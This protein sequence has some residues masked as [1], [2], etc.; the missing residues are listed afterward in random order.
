MKVVGRD[1]PVPPRP[2]NG[3]FSPGWPECPPK[4]VGDG[5]LD[6]PGT[7]RRRK[8]CGASGTPPPTTLINM[9]TNPGGVAAAARHHG[10]TGA[11]R[12]TASINMA[13]NPG[14]CMAAANVRAGHARPRQMAE[15]GLAQF[16]GRT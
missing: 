13:A 8:P 10:G 4:S 15:N 2:H 7:L 5:V 9:D 14:A 6:V 16:S 1:A 3:R 12:P 11:S